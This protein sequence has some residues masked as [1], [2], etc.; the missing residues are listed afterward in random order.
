MLTGIP[1]ADSDV[2]LVLNAGS[3]AG[4]RTARDLLAGGRRVAVV[5]RYPTDL[6]RILHGYDSSRVLALAADT[7]VREQWDR[8]AS[9]VESRLGPIGR[10]IH[11]AGR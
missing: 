7:D 4:Y 9:R 2:V 1:P 6:A 3:D 11:A 10:I 8:V 5:S